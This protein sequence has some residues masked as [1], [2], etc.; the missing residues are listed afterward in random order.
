MS[1]IISILLLL[2]AIAACKSKPSTCSNSYD[3]D[4]QGSVK[5][6][7]SYS[8]KNVTYTPT[9]DVWLVGP[10]RGVHPDIFALIKS[11][12]TENNARPL[13]KLIPIRELYPHYEYE[14]L[15]SHSGILLIPY[16]VS[17]MSFFE[18]YRM[19]IPMIIPTARLLTQWH[20]QYNVLNERTWDLVN[21]NPTVRVSKIP[22]HIN[23]TCRFHSDPNNNVDVEVIQ[24]WVSLSDYYQYPHILLFDN[25]DE[26]IALLTRYSITSK[27]DNCKYNNTLCGISIK[28][29][30]YMITL[31]KQN[32]EKWTGILNKV[33]AYKSLHSR[34]YIRRVEDGNLNAALRRSYGL[35]LLHDKCRGMLVL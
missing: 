20:V 14:D 7:D 22:R 5:V 30:Q 3:G 25:I 1:R 2:F 31:D 32:N 34:S 16:Q 26:L 8:V 12:L 17:L 18:Y 33:K 11:S 28:M 9:K 19:G 4:Y 15:A 10:S 24:E 13:V 29:R 23:S 27:L 35:E 6:G 21:H